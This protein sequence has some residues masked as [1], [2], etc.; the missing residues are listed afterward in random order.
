MDQQDASGNKLLQEVGLWISHK[1]KVLPSKSHIHGPAIPS[2]DSENVYCTLLAHAAVHR[3]MAGYTGFPGGPVKG[4]HR[5]YMYYISASKDRHLSNEVF[6][7]N[8]TIGLAGNFK[9][10]CTIL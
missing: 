1:I 7:C 10:T 4:K 8:E 3:T 6:C 5:L 2:I 9:S